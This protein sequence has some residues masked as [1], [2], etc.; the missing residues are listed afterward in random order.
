MHF[1]YSVQ[2]HM[3]CI[4]AKLANVP[5]TPIPIG[6]RRTG[7]AAAHADWLPDESRLPRPREMR[8]SKGRQGRP[9]NK[10]G[11]DLRAA[12]IVGI[13]ILLSAYS[14]DSLLFRCL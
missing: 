14:Q 2:F 10:R 3:Y 5:D 12:H 6:P 9:A 4:S 1:I 13:K 7:Y 8:W 11:S